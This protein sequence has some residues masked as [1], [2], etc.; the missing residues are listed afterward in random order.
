MAGR[1]LEMSSRHIRRQ[2][3][4]QPN[5]FSF[6]SGT[7][8]KINVLYLN[9]K[10]KITPVFCLKNKQRYYLIRK[11]LTVLLIISEFLVLRQCKCSL[12]WNFFT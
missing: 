7:T 8:S 12:T 9:N 2:V 4:I 10:N 5:S 6:H 3:R 1:A 11:Y